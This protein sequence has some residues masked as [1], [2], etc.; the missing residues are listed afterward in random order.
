MN[1]FE[2]SQS[3]ETEVISNTD[4]KNQETLNKNSNEN[5]TDKTAS[6]A[7]VGF[8]LGLISIISWI[9]PLIGYPITIAGIIFSASAIH[10]KNRR[11]AI[12]GLILSIIC[13]IATLINSILG[14]L[15][16]SMFYYSFN[17]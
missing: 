12:V 4:I 5:D 11:K 10:S 13:L 2:D 6:K 16:S 14:V 15:L 8:V 9:L 17:F 1:L 3:K 7:I